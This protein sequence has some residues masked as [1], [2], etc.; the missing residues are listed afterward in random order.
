M[1][2]LLSDIRRCVHSWLLFPPEFGAGTCTRWPTQ[3]M[4]SPE[5]RSTVDQWRLTLGGQL[6]LKLYSQHR[7]FG[8]QNSVEIEPTDLAR[9]PG[10]EP[11]T[12]EQAER[13][14]ARER[15]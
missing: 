2:W 11:G 9:F 10:A 3:D 12:G 14:R 8:P 5:F 4:L 1:F 13:R 7:D 15:L 6:I